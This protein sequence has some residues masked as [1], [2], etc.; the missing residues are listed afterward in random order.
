MDSLV[1]QSFTDS[2]VQLGFYSSPS[3]GRQDSAIA[4]GTDAGSSNQGTG[5]VAIGPFAGND[6]QGTG[7]VAIGYGA[8]QTTQGENSVAIGY[9][10]GYVNMGNTNTIILNASGAQLNSQESSALYINPIRSATGPNSLVYDPTTY[11]VTYTDLITGPTGDTGPTGPFS[12]ALANK[13]LIS[14]V[15]AITGT[16]LTWSTGQS[17]NTYVPLI[18]DTQ[19][20]YTAPI[21]PSAGLTGWRFNKTYTLIT[22]PASGL[23]SGNTYTIVSLG[24]PAVNWVAIGAAG[25]TAGNQ[26]TYNGTT[27]TGTGGTVTT[28]QKISWFSLNALYGVPLPTSVIPVT[29]VTKA[30][31]RNVWFLVR[32][33]QD[34]ALQGSLAI[35]IESYAYQYTGNTGTNAYTGRW[36]YSFPLQQGYGFSATSTTNITNA[37]GV[38]FPR[39]R[40]GFTYLLYAADTTPPYLP[41]LIPSS[42]F[43]DGGSGLFTPS[44]VSTENTLRDPYDI[45]TEYPHFAMSATQY[46]QNAVQPTYGGTGPYSDQGAVEIASIYLNTSSTS[47]TSGTGQTGTDFNVLAMGYSGVNNS[48]QTQN[49]TLSWV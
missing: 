28:N 30:N 44:Q 23:T 18:A 16:S 20:T 45:Y 11:E 14:S 49:Y 3:V 34:I 8:G 26:F 5:A 32:F 41:G 10:A 12:Q 48:N 15:S 46:T 9:L 35:Q 1:F 33:N 6:T 37:A 25:A 40:A 4:I 29:A 13:L 19:I 39:L 47:P 27:I 24:S 31:L 22:I 42:T 17:G 21:Q 7:S 43:Y 2:R 38:L 36:A